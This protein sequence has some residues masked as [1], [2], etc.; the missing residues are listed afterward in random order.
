MYVKRGILWF[1]QDLR[2]HDN[3]ALTEALRY[4]DEVIPVYVF[5]ERLFTGQTD[6]Y[7]LRKTGRYRAKFI[8]ESVEAL[9]LA[10]KEKGCDLVVRIGKP[11]EIIFELAK[12]VKSS[13]VFCNRERTRD[14]EAVQDRLE[15]NLWSIGQEMRY[16][17][18]KLLYYTA[19]LPF[20]ITHTPDSFSQFRKEVE[21]YVPVREPLPVPEKMP[22]ISVRLDTGVI[23]DMEDLG[24]SDFIADDRSPVEFRG[25]EAEGLRRLN[26]YLWETNEIA[27]YSNRYDELSHID[28]ATR[29]SPWLAQGCLSPKM[30]YQ[31]LKE[32]EAS[33]GKQKSTACI[34]LSLLKRDFF[35]LMAKKYSELIFDENGPGGLDPIY[36]NEDISS[37]QKWKN[38]KTGMPFIDASMREL[39]KTGFLSNRGRMNVAS[40]LIYDLKQNWQMGAEYFESVL[41]DYDIASNWGN[42]HYA[43]GVSSD[44]RESRQLN[45]YSQAQRYDAKGTYVK[46]WI[47]ELSKLSVD[48]FTEPGQLLSY[49]S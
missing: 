40:Y 39:A 48:R 27:K 26:N 36:K 11:E 4:T 19:D 12:Q 45:A 14:E 31:Q 47:P 17:R 29:F 5:D 6:K 9:R 30:V 3:E 37:F 35:R 1:R 44:N 10:L 20:P 22:Y 42:W 7:G 21:R 41:I 32:Y 8:I 16:S 33:F 43:A 46:T 18:G 2:L 28:G 38:G 34:V 25:G 23:P 13:W 15:R 24:Y 49:A